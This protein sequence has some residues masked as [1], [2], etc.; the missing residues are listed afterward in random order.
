M[1]SGASE[2]HIVDV[3]LCG[4]VVMCVPHVCPLSMMCLHLGCCELRSWV[5]WCSLFHVYWHLLSRKPHIM[6][7][8]AVD[9]GNCFI[10]SIQPLSITIMFLRKLHT[11]IHFSFL[12]FFKY[13][14]K[15][16]FLEC[17]S[18]LKCDI[19]CGAVY[20]IS[21]YHSTFF[22]MPIDNGDSD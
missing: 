4:R 7:A 5:G 18:W 11:A 21:L 12:W 2:S 14:I 19:S 1:K 3:V 17:I 10:V 16:Y 8:C 22:F 13:V 6:C 9:T 20:I 15:W